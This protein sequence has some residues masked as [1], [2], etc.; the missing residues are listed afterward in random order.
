MDVKAVIQKYVDTMDFSD[1]DTLRSEYFLSAARHNVFRLLYYRPD[2]AD[3]IIKDQ[4]IETMEAQRRNGN[5]GLASYFMQIIE[6]FN[7]AKAMTKEELRFRIIA[8]YVNLSVTSTLLEEVNHR[9]P[10]C[11]RNLANEAK[12]DPLLS[13][14]PFMDAWKDAEFFDFVQEFPLS[15][16][17][18]EPNEF[19]DYGDQ[20]TPMSS[21]HWEEIQRKIESM[22]KTVED[23]N[24]NQQAKFLEEDLRT[25]E[26]RIEDFAN[27][28]VRH[29][30]KT[31]TKH[32]AN[33]YFPFDFFVKDIRWFIDHDSLGL[34]EQH[35]DQLINRIHQIRVPGFEY[36]VRCVKEPLGL[37]TEIKI[38]HFN[39]TKKS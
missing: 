17:E 11:L 33:T 25:Q 30:E 39:D 31:K 3:I 6:L 4:A 38:N 28:M 37:L 21:I 12:E 23:D 8:S 19:V 18:F 27:D 34:D 1:E 15:I 10:Q 2:M 29:I 22:K 35:L 14:I 24:S 26:Q 32:T 9:G 7:H 5:L 13:K 36:T 20:E 16:T